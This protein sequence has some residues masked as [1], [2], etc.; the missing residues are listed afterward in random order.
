[1]SHPVAWQVRGVVL[2][3]LLGGA[4]ALPLLLRLADANAQ[5]DGSERA[6]VNADAEPAEPAP[7]TPPADTAPR[8]PRPARETLSAPKPRPPTPCA[9]S[10]PPWWARPDGTLREGH[11]RAL[12]WLAHHQEAD[13]SW[14]LTDWRTR[15][16][17]VDVGP[18]PSSTEESRLGLTA[19]AVLAFAW[20]EQT[21]RFG[22]HKRTVN[23]AVRWL[24]RSLL[25]RYAGLTSAS[26]TLP[27][28][29]Q[30]VAALALTELN[31]ITRD[32]TLH[33]PAEEALRRVVAGRE[34]WT[35]LHTAAWATLALASGRRAYLL[36][37]ELRA[38][39]PLN[40]VALEALA[41]PWAEAR[42]GVPAGPCARWLIRGLHGHAEPGPTLPL[43][44]G[45]LRESE[46]LRPA[47]WFFA[48]NAL[49]IAR[50][51]GADVPPR[52]VSAWGASLA[53]ALLTQQLEEGCEAGSWEPRGAA[54]RMHGRVYATAL[55][56]LDL[57]AARWLGER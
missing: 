1:M 26:E 5:G 48:A 29:E 18:D 22:A 30:A 50:Q 42:G 6:D 19:L 28:W 13:G 41:W 4:L 54:S 31:A 39:P 14:S 52:D 40:G 17:D 47:A 11:A 36:R 20:C 24:N 35:D 27:A 21:H 53:Q 32:F 16:R 10:A 55:G 57:R 3:S 23:K 8:P 37:R 2:G 34:T 9:S 25:P 45:R 44:E 56:A 12:R 7:P 51:R 38:V 43:L 15:C 49:D 33:R 46:A